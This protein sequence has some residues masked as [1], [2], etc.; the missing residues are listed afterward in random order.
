M[1]IHSHKELIKLA[2]DILGLHPEIIALSGPLGAGK[3]TLTKE[4][5]KQLGITE[6]IISPT[7]VLETEYKIPDSDKLFIHIDCYRMETLNELIRLGIE[8]RINQ[9]NIIVIEWADKFPEFF[10]KYSTTYVNISLGGDENERT[11][12][13]V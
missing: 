10:K 1:V 8:K 7:Y 13:I 12:E 11:I 5:A 3:T 6:N 4:I 9:N 2:K